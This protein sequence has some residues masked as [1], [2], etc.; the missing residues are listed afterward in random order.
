MLEVNSVSL[1]VI[2]TLQ[3]HGSD[4]FLLAEKSW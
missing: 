2:V 1:H 4:S 3:P